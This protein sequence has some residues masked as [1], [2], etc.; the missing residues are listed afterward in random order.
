MFERK[1]CGGD[2]AP[3]NYPQLCNGTDTITTNVHFQVP[4]PQSTQC[5]ITEVLHQLIQDLSKPWLTICQMHKYFCNYFVGCYLQ[6]M[7]VQAETIN[8]L[9]YSNCVKI[10]FAR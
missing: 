3:S 8:W 9:A 4:S 6:M 7:Q 2:R 10:N 1:L 5:D